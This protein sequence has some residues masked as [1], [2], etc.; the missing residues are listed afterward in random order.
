MSRLL[1]SCTALLAR[2]DT[3]ICDIWGVV[4]DGAHVYEAAAQVLTAFRARGGV[5]VLL[6]NAPFPAAAVK[7][8]IDG[9]GVPRA[10]YDAIVSSGDLTRKRLAQ[11]GWRTVLHIGTDRDLAL[12]AGL[13]IE[14]GA[15]DAAQGVVCTGLYDEQHEGAPD[16]DPLLARCLARRLPMICANPDLSVEV[17]GVVL[18]CAGAIAQRYSARGGSVFYAGK[19][20]RPAYDAALAKATRLR[21]APSREAKVL[22]IGDGMHTDLAGAANAGLDALFI[23]GGLHRTAFTNDQGALDEARITQALARHAL[24]PLA[25]ASA[26]SP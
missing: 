21:G 15:L 12:F 25:I 4:H 1:S 11:L 16:Y 22:A 17:A 10:A 13:D 8:V 7:S 18:P 5:V 19:P 14:R 2:Y 3:L 23:A 24:S 6:S 26:L 9:I 20:H